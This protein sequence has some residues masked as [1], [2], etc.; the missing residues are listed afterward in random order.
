[1][2][3]A[4]LG[5]FAGTAGRVGHR[6]LDHDVHALLGASD[7]GRRALVVR[8][9]NVSQIDLLCGQQLLPIRVSPQAEVAGE[10][11]AQRLRG[12]ADRHNLK[13]FGGLE[14]QHVAAGMK[15]AHTD[16]GDLKRTGHVGDS[17]LVVRGFSA[18]ETSM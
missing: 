3:A 6:L 4:G 15:V 17:P 14:V 7:G 5:D 10:A 8:Q 18:T 13:G 2:P 11:V 9:P 12:V 16:D 1:M